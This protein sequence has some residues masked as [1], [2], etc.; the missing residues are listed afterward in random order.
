MSKIKHYI[1]RK[2][3][4]NT[5]NGKYR[6]EY[7]V[8]CRVCGKR[9]WVRSFPSHEPPRCKSCAGF[10]SYTP[11][12]TER[13]ELRKRGDGYITKQG[14]HLIYDGGAYKPAHRYAFTNLPTDFVVHHI[15]GDKLD[16]RL[17]NLIPLSK[18]E[19]RCAHASLEKC[20]YVFIKSGLVEYNI[21]TNSYNLSSS[22]MKIIELISVNSGE[23]LTVSAEGN[24]EPSQHKTGRCND[25]P[26]EEYIR[27]LM[28]AQNTQTSDVVGEDIVSSA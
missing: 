11:S 19:H 8:E 26:I 22:M 16:N 27:S 21:D 5:A 25:Y 3:I 17:D 24:P 1:E 6:Y 7:L 4:E 15:N 28:E 2:R 23:P 20:S 14:Y 18:K 13:K 9:Y 10:Q 12:K